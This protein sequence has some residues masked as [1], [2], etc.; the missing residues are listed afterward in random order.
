V[1]VLVAPSFQP[2][3]ERLAPCRFTSASRGLTRFPRGRGLVEVVAEPVRV[4]SE[5]VLGADAQAGTS[6]EFS[7]M[8]RSTTTS[9]GNLRSRR[10]KPSTA[11]S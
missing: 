8:E 4:V 6:V 9:G 7:T 10:R 11:S 1:Q 5:P 2:E 3:D